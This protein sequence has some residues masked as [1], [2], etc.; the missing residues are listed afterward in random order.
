MTLGMAYQKRGKGNLGV[1]AKKLL[2]QFVTL[3]FDPALSFLDLSS[4][5][6]VKHRRKTRDK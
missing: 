1:S 4:Y 5:H 2:N 6:S 3:G